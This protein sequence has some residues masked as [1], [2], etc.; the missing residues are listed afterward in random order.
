M[1]E[2]LPECDL[3]KLCPHNPA[4]D[5]IKENPFAEP[6]C[7]HCDAQCE[8]LRLRACEERIKT[9]EGCAD[10]ERI[11]GYCD[12]YAAALVD[13]EETI[14]AALSK[15]ERHLYPELLALNAIWALREKS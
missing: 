10:A 5:L 9:H 1:T 7:Y 8:C 3:A 15:D 12:G 11:E 14:R 2:H 13:A 6:F 4:H